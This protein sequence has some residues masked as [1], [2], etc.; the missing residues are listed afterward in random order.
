M[1]HDRQPEPTHTFFS[2]TAVAEHR[3]K[4]SQ[5]TNM[6]WNGMSDEVRAT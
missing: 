6:E 5:T 3:T 4:R 1:S 2:V